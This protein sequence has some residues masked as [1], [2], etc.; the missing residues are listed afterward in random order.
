[1]KNSIKN[2]GI[3][4]LLAIIVFVLAGC[5]N[6]DNGN[7]NGNDS[8]PS[9][10]EAMSTKS[11]MQY[12]K[13]EGI[14]TGINI[15]NS[16]DAIN[17]STMIADETNWGNPRVNQ[18]Y[19]TGLKNLGF[20]I[21]RIPVTWTGHIGSAPNYLIS[22]TYLQRVA[23]VIGFAKNAGLKAFINIHH[24]GHSN[25]GEP[26]G[27]LS[28]NKAVAGDTSVTDKYYKVWKQIA[29]YFINYGDWLM[30][31]GFNEIHRGDWNPSGTIQE[32]AVINEWNQKFTDAVKY[33]R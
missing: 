33:R 11:A 28:I 24:D 7:G 9:T 14:N 31:Q 22:E 30:F 6:D 10:P 23:E 12:F 5:P 26:D 29:E 16:L 32:Y 4:A 17:W 8:R 20:N 13:D 2:Y 27:W 19:I 1:M 15:G 21:I 25:T 3:I 18:A